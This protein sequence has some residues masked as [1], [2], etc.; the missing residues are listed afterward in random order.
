[1]PGGVLP[2]NAPPFRQYLFEEVGGEMRA[3]PIGMRSA[4]ALGGHG[5]GAA[6]LRADGEFRKYQLDN[7]V[8]DV[9][10]ASPWPPATSAPGA[11]GS[12]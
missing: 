9:T 6:E 10:A 1:M 8:N 3:P 5:T 12:T 11:R 7:S 4:N 2:P